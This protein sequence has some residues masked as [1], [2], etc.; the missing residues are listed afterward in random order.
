M[1]LAKDNPM[2]L[3]IGVLAVGAII[4]F[5]MLYPAVTLGVILP[6]MVLA[7]MSYACVKMIRG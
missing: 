5:V 3:F 2:K 1:F 4:P 7:V 6:C